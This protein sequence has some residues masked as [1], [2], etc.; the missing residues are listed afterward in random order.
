[1]ANSS[2]SIRSGPGR[3]RCKPVARRSFSAHGR[4]SFPNGWSNIA[5]V[6]F[7]VISA[8]ISPV[9]SIRA[10]AA[11]QGKALDRLDLTVMT[12]EEMARGRLEARI[13]ELLKL[14]FNR[15]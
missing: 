14:G 9:E 3:N 10:E 4:S 7:Q 11:K 8:S 1:M 12:V 2:I 15:I 5:T 13:S 6:G